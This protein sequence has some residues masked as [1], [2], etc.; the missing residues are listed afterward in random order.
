M[1]G[2]IVGSEECNEKSTH[3]LHKGQDMKYTSASLASV[4]QR[5]VGTRLRATREEERAVFESGHTGKDHNL[6]CK[7]V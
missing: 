2:Q 6:S 5:M 3:S 7:S 1:R 4:S